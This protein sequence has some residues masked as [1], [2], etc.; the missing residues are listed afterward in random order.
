MPESE[1]SERK[2]RM[3][4]QPMQCSCLPALAIEMLNTSIG[5]KIATLHTLRKAA[6]RS[7]VPNFTAF[8]DTEIE[9][10]RYLLQ[11]ITAMPMCKEPRQEQI[12]EKSIE[13]IEDSLGWKRK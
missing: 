10:Y 4:I 12:P 13:Q 2:R 9:A 6:E 8:L 3:T 5:E 11:M 7:E 1:E